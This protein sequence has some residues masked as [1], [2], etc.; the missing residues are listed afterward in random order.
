MGVIRGM[1][2]GG[3]GG[4]RV[5]HVLCLEF[6]GSS[7]EPA[8]Q[9]APGFL[10]GSLLEEPDFGRFVHDSMSSMAETFKNCLQLSI[11]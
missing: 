11:S 10:Q 4:S 8:P 6:K 3:E 7:K 5:C 1:A 2:Q 9:P